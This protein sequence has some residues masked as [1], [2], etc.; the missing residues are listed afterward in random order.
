MGLNYNPA[1]VIQGLVMYMDITNPRSYSGSGNTVFNLANSGIAATIITGITYD[2]DN[3]KNLNFNGSSGYMFSNDTSMNFSSSDFTIQTTLKLNGLSAGI[4]NAYGSVICAG[5]ALTNNSS[6]LQFSGT[7]T[8]HYAIVLW[9]QPTTTTIGR[10]Y[11][12][13]TNKIYNIAVVKNTSQVEFFVDGA[14][15][16]TTTSSNFFNFTA[17]GFA[18]GRWYYPGYEQY[19]KGNIYDLK[20]YNRALTNDEIAQNYDA[21]KGRYITPE[22]IVT[23]G[24][25][26]NLDSGKSNSY[27]GV[28]NT[29]YDLSGFGNTGTLTNGPTFSGL[30]GGSIVFDSTFKYILFSNIIDTNND[31]TVNFWNRRLSTGSIHNLLHGVNQSGYFQIRYSSS[32]AVQLVKSNAADMGSF[33]GY[34]ST[35]NN[36]VYLTV[37][38]TKSSSTYDLFINGSYISSITNAQ[39]FVT[40]GPVLGSG[41]PGSEHFNGR[42]YSFTCYNRALTQ[43]E[44][45]QNYNATKSRFGL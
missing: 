33:T 14:S 23:N 6:I 39:T 29:I 22:N 41:Y 13:Q 44:V 37:R 25:I 10:N 24:L 32:N 1:S 3:K 28:G 17:N 27:S 2:N 16:G 5:A 40:S 26:L 21:S 34:T 45:L 12:F 18:I 38:F 15:I 4:N 35:A 31:L 30:N 20:A 8:S 7:A 9:H 19:L 11:N 43:Q 42:I 36:D